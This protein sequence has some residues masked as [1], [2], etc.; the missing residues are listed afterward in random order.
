MKMNKI[1]TLLCLFFLVLMYLY[2]CGGSE[3]EYLEDIVYELE[4]ST[5]VIIIKEWCFLLGSGAE[6]YYKQG[7]KTAVLLGKTT[8]GDDGFC[9]FK[10][11]MYEI[12][13]NGGSICVSWCFRPSNSNHSLWRSKSFDLP[14]EQEEN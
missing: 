2:G 13:Q 5:G 10:E 4:D 12:T 11:G 8:G 7:E 1:I 9:P 3:R 14:K 6:V